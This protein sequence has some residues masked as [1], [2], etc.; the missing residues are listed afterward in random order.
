MGTLPF[1][2]L[3]LSATALGNNFP[4]GR[5]F[6]PCQRRAAFGV[7]SN[8][9]EAIEDDQLE[10]LQ[11]LTPKAVLM[12][13]LTKIASVRAIHDAAQDA[14]ESVDRLFNSTERLMHRTT[15]VQDF[16]TSSLAWSELTKMNKYAKDI[17]YSSLISIST[18]QR[19]K[20]LGLSAEQ[21][22]FGLPDMPLNESAVQ[23]V[24]P[25]NLIVDCIPGKYRTYSGHCN[26]VNNPLMGAIYEPFQRLQKPDYA[27]DVS[28][29]RVSSKGE[30]LPNPREISVNLITSSPDGHGECS[31]M[32]AQWAQF[33]HSDLSHIGS[34]RLFVGEQSI[35]LPC[36][37]PNARHPEC[38]P[39]PI[40]ETDP[41]FKGSITCMTYS[42]TYTAPRENCTLGVRE[43]GNLA[44][45]FLDGSH[46]YGSTT[47]RT[48]KLRSFRNGLLLVRAQSGR[49]DLPPSGEEVTEHCASV[50]SLQP[51]FL[52]GSEDTN[53]FPTNAALHTIWIRQHNSIAQK[54]RDLNGHW[55]DERLYQE[56]RRIVTAQIQHITYNEFLPL[57]VG[58]ETA[59]QFG[60]NVR[61]RAFDSDYELKADAS[62]LNEYASTVGFFFYSL[63]PDRLAQYADTGDR[64]HEKLLTGFYNDPSQLYLRGR[65]DA[66]LRF[67]MRDPI[68]KPGLHMSSE[69]RD[70]FL[71]GSLEHGLDLP[72]LII[73]MGRDHGI[74]SYTKWRSFCGLSVPKNF[75]ELQEIVLESVDINAMKKLYDDIEDVDLFVLGLAEKPKRGALVGP[76]FACIIGNQFQ[77]TK[78]GDR[79]WYENFFYP[80][81]F[82][83]EQLNEIRKV[84]LATVICENTDN[85]GKVQQNVFMLAD[86]YGNCP[87]DC[88]TTFFEQMN[89]KPWLD[90]EPKL[91][92]PI[93][94]HTLEKAIRLGIEQYQRLQQAEAGRI[95]QTGGAP[96]RN[97]GSAISTHA[98]LMAPKRES[99]DIARTAAVL[100]ETTKVLVRGDGLEDNEKLP[101]ELDISTLQRLLPEVDIT[102]IIGNIS[103]FLGPESPNRDE[104]L[105]QPLPCDHTTKF[106]TFSGWCN[107]LRFPS[108][109]N[110]FGPLRRLLDPAYEDGFDSPRIKAR[111]GRELPSA[112]S[113]SNIIHRDSPDFHVKFT[114]MLMQFGQIIDHDMTHS[115]VA[116]GPNNAILNCSRCDSYEKVS[117]HCF[118]IKIDRGDPHFPHTHS[119]GTPRCMSFT[120]SLLGQVT[121]GYR[122]QLNQLTSFLDAS[123]IYGSTECE[124]NSLR[125]FNQ[126]KMNFTDL[127]FNKEALPQ[128]T[129]ERDC[130]SRPKHPCFNAGDERSNEQPGLAV[131]HTIWLREHN[132]VATTLNKINNFWPDERVFQEARR[133]TIAKHQHIVYNEWL[134]V[135]LGCE[136]MA[137]YD[138]TPKKTGYYHG[139]DEHCDAAITQELSTS[140]FRFGHT[141]IRAIYPRKNSNYDDAAPPFDLKNSFGNVSLYYDV[142]GGHMESILIGLVGAQSMAYD[143]HIV[144]AVRNHLFQKPGGPLTG[145]DLPALN[146][147]RARDHGVQP[148]N[149]YREMCGMAR[150]RNFDDLRDVMD[151]STIRAFRSIYS[152]V[153][154]I[155]LF[156]GLMSERPIKGALVGPMLACLIAEQF[157]RLKRCDRFYYENDH[158]A[159]RFTP[160]QLAEIRRTTA[161]K[162]I[163]QNSE[164][165]R[166]IQPNAFLMPDDLTN[167]PVS[168]KDLPESDLYEW[169]DRQFCVV[170][171]RVINLGKTKRITPCITC[172]CTAEGPECHSV[173]VGQCE[174]LLSDY[175][176]SEILEDTVCVIQCSSLIKRRAGRL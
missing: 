33:V 110:A 131:L 88:N 155:D 36:C 70:K 154:D 146:I 120:R 133:I 91:K 118:P 86:N 53:L 75:E 139:Y 156:P 132:R 64:V 44:S 90:Q 102:R 167:A 26:N 176:F 19:L 60:L 32:L 79:F 18:T 10:S 43:Q 38:M 46:I 83:E 40:S 61:T 80:S 92:L 35:M 106:R 144:D 87:V 37:D 17:T 124:A 20:N 22:A 136:T 168:C 66:T 173:V 24:C 77:K 89:A 97:S 115:P 74:S 4:C 142:A 109:G 129:Q 126:G 8:T 23:S 116:R 175:L 28:S 55:D 111:S 9:I 105:P 62:T 27:D 150:A 127:G 78:R 73:Q 67:L 148:Y 122:N 96:N 82:T 172:T 134:P 160:D 104:C 85:I 112:R 1:L 123:F 57:I 152:H 12:Q 16:T 94:K 151:E 13:N 50:S 5:S 31:L 69:L 98:N 34:N 140:A 165:A 48:N 99:L 153:D 125:L 39:M 114:H 93:T 158:P 163:C 171:H 71:K 149:A 100:R 103:D 30:R 56:A 130:R 119:D 49:G 157:Q 137:R 95:S 101:A 15:N 42:R 145:L 63:L 45:S 6:T 162:L 117:I 14:K 170:D 68:R 108:Y 72:A 128:G 81:A 141:L 135:V 166:A 41:V 29:P 161:S 113:I 147:Q 65:L 25:V 21:V 51:C 138:L 2:V 174:N 121:L 59:A 143:R 3:L 11:P 58:K 164:Y 169:L 76:T 7:T 54:L 84:T 52:T 47:E 107:N 159:T